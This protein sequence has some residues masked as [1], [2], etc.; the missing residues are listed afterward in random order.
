MKQIAK[1][2]GLLLLFGIVASA[3]ADPLYV[4]YTEKFNVT[5][6][7][8][9]DGSTDYV[10]NNLT[11]YITINNSA[12]TVEDT[13]SDVW[14]AVNISNNITGL[15]EVNDTTPKGYSIEDSA[16]GY[17]D[18]PTGLTYIHIPVLPN[19]TYLILKF[20]ID[21][22]A[23]NIGCPILVDEAYSATKIPAGKVSNWTVYM[24]ISRNTT[25][26][27]TTDTVVNVEM[28]NI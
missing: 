11:G 8:S 5:A 26:L 21:T 20:G 1:M 25:A 15:I 18:L 10:I 12:T 3:Y 7:V 17:T 14:V 27:P 6:N 28:T 13:L 9:G 16:P 24:N 23:T 4:S 2:L 19:G 22:N